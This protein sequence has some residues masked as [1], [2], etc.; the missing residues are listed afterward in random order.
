MKLFST[1]K[2]FAIVFLY[3]QGHELLGKHTLNRHRAFLN[4]ELCPCIFVLDPSVHCSKKLRYCS[5][6]TQMCSGNSQE[7]KLLATQNWIWPVSALEWCCSMFKFILIFN[8]PYWQIHHKKC[9]PQPLFWFIF[10][11][12]YCL[13][14]LLSLCHVRN[15]LSCPFILRNFV[16]LIL[17]FCFPAAGAMWVS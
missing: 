13:S 6:K 11:F 9:N 1:E 16:S 3:H 8:N 12:H 10:V 2:M 4:L 7:N 17:F 5:L 15:C 14:L